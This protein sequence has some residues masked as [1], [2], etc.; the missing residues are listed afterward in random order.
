[1]HHDHMQDRM[2]PRARMRLGLVPALDLS[3]YTNAI[4]A[5]IIEQYVTDSITEWSMSESFS[6]PLWRN[7]TSCVQCNS[8]SGTCA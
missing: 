4:Y 6:E 5:C 1:M 7:G 8:S 2:S 3:V